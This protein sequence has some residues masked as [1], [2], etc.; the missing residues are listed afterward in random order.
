MSVHKKC[1]NKRQHTILS[2]R[3][4][5]VYSPPSNQSTFLTTS[6]KGFVNGSLG[7]CELGPFRTF[8]PSSNQ[9]GEPAVPDQR[10][11]KNVEPLNPKPDPLRPLNPKP[12]PL[13]PSSL[14]GK[15]DLQLGRKVTATVIRRDIPVA[16]PAFPCAIQNGQRAVGCRPA[17]AIDHLLDHLS[18]IRTD[19]PSVFSPWL[20]MIPID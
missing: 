4:P 7:S 9:S 14:R 10:T 15:R 13:R 8:I 5:L 18:N 11:G 16:A 6:F 19:I 3:L 1:A 17:P 20:Q 2:G 12:D